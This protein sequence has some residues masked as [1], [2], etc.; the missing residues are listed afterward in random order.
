MR[1]KRKGWDGTGGEGW[2]R[3]GKLGEEG[4]EGE[5][6]VTPSEKS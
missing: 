3:G 2:G 4:R 6:K 5:G 1:G